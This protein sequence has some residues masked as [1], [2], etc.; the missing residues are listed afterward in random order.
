VTELEWLRQEKLEVQPVAINKQAEE[1]RR[2]QLFMKLF[3][4]RRDVYA[5][6]WETAEGRKG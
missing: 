3:V 5:K 4:G 2:I 6:R 1:L